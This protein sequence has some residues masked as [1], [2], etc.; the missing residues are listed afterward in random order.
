MRPTLPDRTQGKA[1]SGPPS[2]SRQ[3]PVPARGMRRGFRAPGPRHDACNQG[4]IAQAQR[5]HI[6]TWP[7]SENTDRRGRALPRCVSRVSV[8]APGQLRQRPT[9]LRRGIVRRPVRYR[10][11][12]AIRRRRRRSRDSA[13][14]SA[15]SVLL[16]SSS[17]CGAR[18]RFP[19]GQSWQPSKAKR[20][21]IRKSL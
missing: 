6:A 13:F 4:G 18:S 3:R 11:T 5:A 9:R 20:V 19:C 16:A 1:R 2:F 8:Q 10:G 15:K 17:A 12:P 21:R 7:G 14:R